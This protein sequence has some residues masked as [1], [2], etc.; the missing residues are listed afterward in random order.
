MSDDTIE[1]RAG[2][3]KTREEEN[4]LRQF[5]NT[6]GPK[7]AS[8]AYRDNFDRIFGKK[9]DVLEPANLVQQFVAER[10]EA[11]AALTVFCS[12]CENTFPDVE[13]Y[14]EHFRNTHLLVPEVF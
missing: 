13:S 4:L 10:A 6:D 7:G 1:L 12:N 8:R 2:W 9:E 14:N 11:V 5:T 3:K